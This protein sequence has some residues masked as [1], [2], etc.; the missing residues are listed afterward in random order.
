MISTRIR[1]R[2]KRHPRRGVVA[3]EFA[4]AATVLF[5]VIA[6]SIEFSRMNMLRH[7]VDNAAY[8]AARAG[9]ILRANVDDVKQ[10]A[11]EIM[12]SVRARGTVVEVTPDTIQDDTPEIVV[13]VSVP[14]DQNGFVTPRF[15]AGRS[16]VGQCRLTRDD[17]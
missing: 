2:R 17:I 13:T 12:N 4:F 7:S 3:V 11:N 6:I 10:T 8:E 1:N 15:F 16:F 14:A 5:L 9:I